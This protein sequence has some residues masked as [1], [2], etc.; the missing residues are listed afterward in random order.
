MLQ[1]N[2]GYGW[3]DL[4]SYEATSEG[5]REAKIDEDAYIFTFVGD[6]EG[7]DDLEEEVIEIYNTI[8]FE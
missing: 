2:Y 1:G 7:F 8:E 6:E 5:R 4:S 3:D